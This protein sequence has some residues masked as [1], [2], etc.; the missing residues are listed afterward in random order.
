MSIEKIHL[1][2]LLQ[3]F[4]LPAN[5]RKSL[6]RADIRNDL[7]KALGE[8][9]DG[10]DFHG[11]FWA[12]AKSHVAGQ[13]DLRTAV[14]NR[15]ASNKSRTR[16]YPL[17]AGGFLNWWDEKRRWR[18]EP[19]EF[20]SESVKAQSDENFR[21]KLNEKLPVG[22]KIAN[23]NVRPDVGNYEVVFAIIS[24]SNNPLDIP[25]FSKVTLR[26]ARRRLQGFGYKVTRKRS[27]IF[28]LWRRRR[29]K[30]ELS[31]KFNLAADSHPLHKAIHHSLFA[32][33]VEP[34]GQLVA[35]HGGD[36]AVA[37]FLVKHAGADVEG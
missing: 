12:D 30:L 18:N 17:L 4:Y 24:K 23:T 20:M 3:L 6:L 37:E 31:A 8:S 9:T 29:E 16:L 21:E 7:N 32:G 10:G 26:N 14:K 11:P 19:F 25:F 28:P 2:K 34:D 35:V 36:V 27:A 33:V 13:E 22:H 5:K 15:I 1:R